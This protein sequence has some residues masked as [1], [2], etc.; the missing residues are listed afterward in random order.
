MTAE[1][2]YGLERIAMYLQGVDSVYDL[3]WTDD[4]S[5]GDLYLQNE[6][7]MSAYNFTHAPIETLFEWFSILR[8]GERPACGGRAPAPR[9]RDGPQGLAPVSTCS[10]RA[11]RSR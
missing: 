7:E 10:T 8:S 6:R 5:Y 4:V 11:G 3:A 1:L 2:T 9:L